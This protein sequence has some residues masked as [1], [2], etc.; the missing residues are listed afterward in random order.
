MKIPAYILMLI[1]FLFN[2]TA[3]SQTVINPVHISGCNSLVASFTYTTNIPTVT[4]VLWN[5]GG[6]PNDTS[7]LA[8]PGPISF[9]YG[10]RTVTLVLNGTDR[11]QI[12]VGYPNNFSY[13]HTFDYGS[14]TIIFQAVENS[15]PPVTYHWTIPD[16]RPNQSFS[17][18]P[19]ET[20][21]IYPV[22]VIADDGAGCLDTINQQIA[23][24]DTFIVPNVFTPNDDLV[25]NEFKVY[26]NGKDP[27]T[28]KIF[29][30]TGQ[31]IFENQARILMWDGRLPSGQKALPGIYFYVIERTG[32]FPVKQA[33][34]FYLYL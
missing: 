7:T 28:L 8:N 16:D 17:M 27:I 6:G 30:R 25:N 10:V 23:V 18:H 26:S 14:Y 33:G 32:E 15:W 24:Q 5:F 20:P 22:R 29:S 34:F 19:Y 1:G 4:S 13:T 21:G 12:L 11:T 9:P 2:I 3:E 31:K